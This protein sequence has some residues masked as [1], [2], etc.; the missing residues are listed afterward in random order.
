[1]KR[2]VLYLKVRVFRGY[3]LT[4]ETLCGLLPMI[5]AIITRVEE[6]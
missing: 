4:F 5:H 6:E 3:V 1:M 2:V